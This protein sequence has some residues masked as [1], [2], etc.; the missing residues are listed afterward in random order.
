VKE[1]KKINKQKG[2]AM[3][4]MGVQRPYKH[5]WDRENVKGHW[6]AY[7]L[8][9]P[10]QPAANYVVLVAEAKKAQTVL[11]NFYSSE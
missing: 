4:R 5:P 11:F 10:C 8:A 3:V 2:Q 6:I 1:Q 9:I 7:C